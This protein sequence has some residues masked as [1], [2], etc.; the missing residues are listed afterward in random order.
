MKAGLNTKC[1]QTKL[2]SK[3]SKLQI[4]FMKATM[5]GAKLLAA[6]LQFATE[7]PLVPLP[8]SCAF[9]IRQQWASRSTKPLIVPAHLMSR[10]KRKLV[11]PDNSSERRSVQHRQRQHTSGPDACQ[12]LDIYK[13]S[14]I[15]YIV[16]QCDLQTSGAN[17]RLPGVSDQLRQH[18]PHCHAIC[19]LSL[20]CTVCMPK[21]STKLLP[22]RPQN[23]ALC[24]SIVWSI[25]LQKL[26]QQQRQGFWPLQMHSV[27]AAGH[28]HR[29]RP[30][31][32]CCRVCCPAA[33]GN[34]VVGASN[35]RQLIM[36][37]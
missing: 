14:S 10:P 1:A 27:A 12:M 15:V 13:T 36:G 21:I 25:N 6:L 4:T 22:M 3:R 19:A 5:N 18:T 33:T 11:S 24:L 9:V 30:C 29:R 17:V 7:T 34:L 26:M 2:Q 23:C 16:Q 8:G 37:I 20:P 31:L 32:R 28:L 35:R